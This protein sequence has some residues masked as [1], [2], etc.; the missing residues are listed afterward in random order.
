MHI[1]NSVSSPRSNGQVERYSYL[2]LETAINT[3]MSEEHEWHSV[4]P[5][6]EWGINNKIYVSTD[7]TPHRLMFGFDQSNQSDL[8]LSKRE[9]Q[10]IFEEKMGQQT[11]KVKTRFDSE[12]KAPEICKTDN[13]VLWSGSGVRNEAERKTGVTFRGPYRTTSVKIVALPIYA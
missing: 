2:T 10:A 6:I 5:D 9:D 7:F 11:K 3:S 8:D 12:L 4:L 13:F 1:L